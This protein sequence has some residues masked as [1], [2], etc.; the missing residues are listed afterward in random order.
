M[1]NWRV[2][3]ENEAKTQWDRWLLMLEGAAIHQSYG[4]G[5]T[6]QQ[7]GWQVLRLIACDENQIPVTLVQALVRR[8]RFGVALIWVPGGPA[9]AVKYCD[10]SFRK[11]LLKASGARQIYCRFNSMRAVTSEDE[12]QMKKLGWNIPA[13]R[14]MS[15]LSLHY[16]P[17]LQEETRLGLATGNWRHNLKRSAKY[18]LK[19][20]CWHAPDVAQVMFMYQ[21]MEQYKGLGA[22][23]THAEVAAMF[24]S[25][26]D[27]LVLYRCDDAEGTPIALRGCGTLGIWGWDLF[28]AATPAARKVYASYAVF[29]ALMQ[30]CAERG[31]Q[32]YDMG[33]IDPIGNRGVYDFKKGCGSEPLN[34]L[35]EW[36]WASHWPLRFAANWMMRRRGGR[37]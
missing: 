25:M 17:S 3:D 14:L 30:G 20:Y 19:T 4:W 9:G 10:D 33:G 11:A 36:E 26:G 6:K 31:I 5:L 1:T 13:F 32:H 15:G 23:T 7:L 28:A 12:A 34:Y 27:N 35:G 37:L 29:W 24:D 16:N 22:Q 8:Y 2:V 21:G 18:G